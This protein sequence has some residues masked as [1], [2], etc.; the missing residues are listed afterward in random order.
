MMWTQLLKA[1]VEGAFAAAA[2]LVKLVGP[3]DL[4]WK[5]ATGTNWLTTAQLLQHLG[6]SCGAAF[7]G[8]ITGEWKDDSV[9]PDFDP[10][11]EGPL[12]PAGKYV[13]VK[14]V[15][16]AL[17]RLEA[18]RALALR[19]IDRAGEA[20]LEEKKVAP[21]WG[22]PELALGR[23]LLMMIDHLK[24]HRSQLFYYLKLQ[25]KPVGTMQLYGM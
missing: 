16:D 12:P 24:N 5:P 4:A 6:N 2:G 18:D 21:P 19:M 3:E 14:S 11:K 7:L 8:F 1:E 20:A 22:G 9:S 10:A 23:H 17:R 13:A 25:G 15:D